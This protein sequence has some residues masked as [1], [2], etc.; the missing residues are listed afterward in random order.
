MAFQF[1]RG[2]GFELARTGS[3][4]GKRW[5]SRHVDEGIAVGKPGG[6]GAQLDLAAGSLG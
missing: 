1:G 6:S 2:L 3:D 5:R 4:F